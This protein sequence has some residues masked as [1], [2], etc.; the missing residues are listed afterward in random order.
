MGCGEGL[1]DDNFYTVGFGEGLRFENCYKGQK[2]VYINGENY[3]EPK[4]VWVIGG[5]LLK[6]YP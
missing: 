6:W 3:I 1:R 2:T 4:K 5:R